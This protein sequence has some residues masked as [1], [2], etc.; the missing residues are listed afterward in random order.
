MPVRSWR[1]RNAKK[2]H[3]GHTGMTG[4]SMQACAPSP[5][6]SVYCLLDNNADASTIGTDSSSDKGR[7]DRA[8]VPIEGLQ[9]LYSVFLPPH[10]QLNETHRDKRQKVSKRSAVYKKDS[11]T[12]A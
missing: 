6:R 3:Q 11:R 5:D 7:D 8:A 10:L 4:F 12:T 9:C 2:R 1:S